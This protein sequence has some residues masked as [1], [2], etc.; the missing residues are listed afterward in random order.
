MKRKEDAGKLVR[1]LAEHPEGL[2]K[3]AIKRNCDIGSER[4]FYEVLNAARSIS[5]IE[6]DRHLY[7]VA[8]DSIV[9]ESAPLLPADDE[10]IALLTI[11]HI[12]T[13]MTSDILKKLFAPL[14]RRFD[15]LLTKLIKD[16]ATWVKRIRILD[17]HYRSIERGVFSFLTLAISRK[18]AICFDY[19]DSDGKGSRRIVSPQQLV[20]YK[21][22]WYLDA[23]CHTQNGLRIFS[24]DSISNTHFKNTEY[25]EIAHATLQE[26]FGTSY[27][28]FSGKAANIAKIIFTGK[29]ARYA[30]REKW[31]PE[32]KLSFINES[33]IQLEIPYNN[34][35]ELLRMILYWG[36]DA[37][38][39]APDTL[40]A[41][42]AAMIFA[43]AAHYKDLKPKKT[44]EKFKKK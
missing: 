12:L 10:L 44:P 42:I 14:Q 18:R 29:A 6:C 35:S 24:L 7:K 2:P 20:R 4:T 8:P 39:I 23:W 38:V 30:N 13:A 19:I 3:H 27:G 26:T 1:L 31:H 36:D 34:P 37:Q 11:K 41:E 43:M 28:I 15:T 5:K 21:D 25:K 32:Q 17:I 9:N 22:N 16:P 33:S 40:R